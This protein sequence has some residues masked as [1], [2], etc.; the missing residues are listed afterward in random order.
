MS[1]RTQR[2]LSLPIE[3]VWEAAVCIP[4][5]HVIRIK[6]SGPA[7]SA[8][9]NF[10]IAKFSRRYFVLVRNYGEGGLLFG[11]RYNKSICLLVL[12]SFKILKFQIKIIHFQD[13]IGRVKAFI[14]QLKDVGAVPVGE[15]SIQI[16]S[17]MSQYEQIFGFNGLFTS[18]TTSVQTLKN[19]YT[20]AIGHQMFL[21]S[22]G[23]ELEDY[24]G[25]F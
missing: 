11:I 8:A 18:I 10:V 6:R 23:E 7:R 20:L 14:Q 4:A 3:L 24:P 16:V 5:D 25:F 21:Q 2:Q 17:A 13:T 1:D 12:K 9:L 19:L 15:P 22:L